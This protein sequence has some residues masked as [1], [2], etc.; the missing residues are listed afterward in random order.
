M[1][2]F[3]QHE[4]AGIITVPV[5]RPMAKEDNK[6]DVPTTEGFGDADIRAEVDSIF[7][8]DSVATAQIIATNEKTLTE[9]TDAGMGNEQFYFVSALVLIFVLLGVILFER[10]LA[11]KTL[12][13]L[14]KDVKDLAKMRGDLSRLATLVQGVVFNEKNTENGE[15][16]PRRSFNATKTSVLVEAGELRRLRALERIYQ[17]NVEGLIES[18][19]TKEEG[20]YLGGG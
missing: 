5:P 7:F 15:E 14:T 2:N 4:R 8:A 20:K 10:I 19:Q 17:D 12:L 1:K 11:N 6:Q 16:K 13:S 3:I 18:K 9:R